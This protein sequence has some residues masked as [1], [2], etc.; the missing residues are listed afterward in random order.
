MTDIRCGLRTRMV[1]AYYF[2]CYRSSKHCPTFR[3]NKYS[4]YPIGFKDSV[5]STS[6]LRW[7]K[8]YIMEVRSI[9]HHIIKYG[10]GGWP[11]LKLIEYYFVSDP[12]LIK[13]YLYHSICGIHCGT[14]GKLVA[15]HFY[16]LS[17]WI[18]NVL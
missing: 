7:S 13:H 8:L 17:F 15:V 6:N 1:N 12:N 16:Y 2:E 4:P 18:T 5:F 9:F 11:L 3:C 10:V 14:L